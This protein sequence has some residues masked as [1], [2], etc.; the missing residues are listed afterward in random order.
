LLDVARVERQLLYLLLVDQRADF[1]RARLDHR[2]FR[3]H[4]D[5][6]LETPDLQREVHPDLGANRHL[7]AL[8]LLGEALEFRGNLV[9]SDRYRSNLVPALVIRHAAPG[10]SRR[11]LLRGHRHARHHAAGLVGHH[12]EDGAR[13]R[14]RLGR[15]TGAHNEY[16]RQEEQS[17]RR[18]EG[19]D[20]REIRAS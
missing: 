17:P 20:R 2:G 14:L 18:H 13:H 5:G 19:S 7:H 4:D 10:E 6:L 8:G 3:R 12:A 9:G 16:H 15:E 11:S 1:S